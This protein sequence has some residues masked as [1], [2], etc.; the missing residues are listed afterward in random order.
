MKVKLV[1]LIKGVRVVSTA[2]EVSGGDDLSQGPVVPGATGD[3]AG[4]LLEP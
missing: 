1:A 2:A 4:S 3:Q